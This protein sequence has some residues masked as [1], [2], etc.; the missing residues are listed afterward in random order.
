MMLYKV[1]EAVRG[2]VRGGREWLLSVKHLAHSVVT[3]L[4]T[5]YSLLN[6]GE[7]YNIVEVSEE[8]SYY[9]VELEEF[10]LH[11]VRVMLFVQVNFFL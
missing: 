10:F 7:V 2:R 9:L 6:P 1:R 11:R 5:F 8:P 3:A 4:K